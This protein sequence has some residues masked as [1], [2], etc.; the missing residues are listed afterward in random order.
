MPPALDRDRFLELVDQLGSTGVL[1]PFDP[2]NPDNVRRT[3]QA[4]ASRDAWERMARVLE[5]HDRMEEAYDESGPAGRVPIW[6]STRAG[7]ASRPPS[8]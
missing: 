2:H 1:L 4:E 3:R 6:A 5:A 8:A 7:P